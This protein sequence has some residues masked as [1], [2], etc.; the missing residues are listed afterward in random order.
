MLII[1][2][3]EAACQDVAMS[4]GKAASLSKL[5]AKYPVPPGFCLTA[6]AHALWATE[7][8][9]GSLQSELHGLLATAYSHLAQQ[10]RTTPLRVAVRSS[11][12][13]EDGQTA[14]FAG[15]Y[16][17]Y[18]NVSGLDKVVDAVTRCWASA[19]TERVQAYRQNRGHAA[20]PQGMAVLVQEL[21][22]ADVAFVAFSAHPGTGAV[23]EV[24]INSNWGLGESIM[25]GAMV[26]DMY[27]V[28]KFDWS[29]TA[30]TI[31]EKQRMTVV[32]SAGVEEVNIPRVLRRQATLT[33]GQARVI[34]Q[35][36]T[37]LEQEF[38]WPVDIEGA[39]VADT[40]YLLQCRPISVF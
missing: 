13:G 27:V 18:L 36:A 16:A 21:V 9:P 5:A 38:K 3:D 17:T 11:A 34:A 33:V 29:L 22:P 24:V 23:D 12:I 37:Q 1:W 30:Q 7:A 20:P 40:L 10:S 2:L 31:A 15:Q 14:S 8:D 19:Q 28:R 4:G 39:Y 6:Q 25:N 32:R 26:P 35:L